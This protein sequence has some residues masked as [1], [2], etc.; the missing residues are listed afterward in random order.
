MGFL[1]YQRYYDLPG[2]KPVVFTNS[3]S[4]SNHWGQANPSKVH[5]TMGYIRTNR[6]CLRDTCPSVGDYLVLPLS[7]IVRNSG[8]VMGTALHKGTRAKL[9]FPS[10]Y[11]CSQKVPHNTTGQAV[12]T[13]GTHKDTKV[14][15]PHQPDIRYSMC[16]SL[17]EPALHV[18]HLSGNWGTRVE[19]VLGE[20]YKSH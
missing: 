7:A 6:R 12:Y 5:F 8:Y 20:K 17:G 2:R 14:T 16:T 1:G 3:P 4:L 18:M 11:L 13:R 9:L 10:P 19:I 15:C